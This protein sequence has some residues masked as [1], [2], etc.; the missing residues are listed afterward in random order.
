M[1]LL[2]VDDEKIVLTILS[3][4]IE[5]WGYEI[6][7]AANGEEAWELLQNIHEPIILLVDWMMSGLDGVALCKMVKNS[8]QATN[9]H[10]IMLTAKR[11][12]EDMLAGFGAGADD[13]L[14]KPVDPR[15]LSS[16]LS[17]GRRLLKYKYDLEQRNL[18]LQATTK[19]MENIMIE[20]NMVN[21]KLRVLSM[22]DELTNVA[23][24]R[25]MEDYLAREWGY[26]MRNR[27]PLTLIMV[28][29]DF[30]KL[31]NDTY[32]HQAGDECLRKVANVLHDTVTRS[33][34]LVA[35]YGGEEFIVALRNTSKIGGQQVG[36]CLRQR[37]EELRIPHSASEIAPYITISLGVVTIVPECGHSYNELIDKADQFMYRAKNSGRNRW[38]SIEG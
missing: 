11:K 20:L 5:E 23:N 18:V 7:L 14:S 26:A 21:E 27:E 33:G 13:F 31:Y 36:E 29:V 1:K 25:S 12:M 8:E 10:V 6:M 30:F 22:V 2:I 19:A 37:V 15:E 4:M 17:V 24:R 35:R 3:S 16:R 9:T 38:V 32:G 34:D 28:D